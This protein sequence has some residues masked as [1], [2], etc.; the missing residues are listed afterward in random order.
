MSKNTTQCKENFKPFMHRITM[1][2]PPS[3][4]PGYFRDATKRV[5]QNTTK[6][7]IPMSDVTYPIRN[8]PKNV[9]HKF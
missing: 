4:H 9:S 5:V 3:L 7:T 2:F 6:T 1:P 8:K